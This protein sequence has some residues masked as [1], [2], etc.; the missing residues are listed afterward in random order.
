MNKL[1]A[2]ETLRASMKKTSATT[3]KS[4]TSSQSIPKR[5]TPRPLFRHGIPPKMRRTANLL[6]ENRVQSIMDASRIVSSTTANVRQV[7][8]FLHM[9]AKSY[10]NI[11]QILDMIAEDLSEV[12]NAIFMHN[13]FDA[14]D[15][16]QTVTFEN[17]ADNNIEITE[18]SPASPT[19]SDATLEIC[20]DII[21]QIE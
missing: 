16:S 1:P 3:M 4:N 13:Y 11:I 2:P 20:E 6:L 5:T 19:P 15:S 21:A 7:N 17:D 12:N 18:V 14:D 9:A 10:D 8:K